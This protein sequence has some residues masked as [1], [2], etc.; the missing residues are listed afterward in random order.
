MPDFIVLPDPMQS[1]LLPCE[2]PNQL[3][4][5]GITLRAAVLFGRISSI[6]EQFVGHNTG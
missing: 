2:Q 6:W 3:E 4:A 5:A 1:D